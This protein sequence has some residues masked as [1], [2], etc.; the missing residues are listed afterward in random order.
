MVAWNIL[1][2]FGIVYN[3]PWQLDFAVFTEKKKGSDFTLLAAVPCQCFFWSLSGYMDRRSLCTT[4]FVTTCKEHLTVATDCPFKL[5]KLA[6]NLTHTENEQQQM[7]M[8]TSTGQNKTK[9][10]Q[11]VPPLVGP[12]QHY[13]PSRKNISESPFIPWCPWGSAGGVTTEKKPRWSQTKR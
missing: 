4:G 10:K 12:K 5:S 2:Y 1:E 7:I 3:K 9:N 11:S 6:S 13:P 8:V